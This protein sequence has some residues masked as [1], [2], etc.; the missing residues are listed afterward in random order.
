MRGMVITYGLMG[1][2][3]EFRRVFADGSKLLEIFTGGVV[4]KG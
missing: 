1:C 2:N 3:A 4:L